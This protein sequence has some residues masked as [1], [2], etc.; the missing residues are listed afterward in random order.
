MVG[1]YK[2]QLCGEIYS[3]DIEMKEVKEKGV[4]LDH[5]LC[6][7]RGLSDMYGMRYLYD[8]HNAKDH[9]GI[10]ELVGFEKGE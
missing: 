1:K 2:C 10:A 5:I 6:A 9:I 8:F 7:K 4:Q 3:K